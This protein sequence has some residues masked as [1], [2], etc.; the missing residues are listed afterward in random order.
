M[1]KRLAGAFLGFLLLFAVTGPIG[2]LNLGEE[3]ANIFSEVKGTVTVGEP[4][5]YG[6]HTIIPVVRWRLFAAGS[7][8][9]R[10]FD[11]QA[12]GVEIEPL[13]LILLTKD[14]FQVIRIAEGYLPPDELAE[15]DVLPLGDE[16]FER[17]LSEGSALMRSGMLEQ[18]REI[19]EILV[20]SR[21]DSAQAHAML[22]HVYGLLAEKAPELGEKIR[23]GMDAFREFARALEID[24]ENP[25]ALMARGYARMIVPPPLGGVEL[26]I[27]D[28]SLALE[29]DPNLVLAMTGLAEAYLSIGNIDRARE[30]FEQALS[31]EPENAQALRGLNKIKEGG[32]Q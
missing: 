18:A 30:L 24:P 9:G 17:L 15:E 21:P 20:R 26:A 14:T 7:T 8:P 29:H 2:A 31:I 16:D 12:G 1:V 13:A 11:W 32:H 10:G 5:V 25:H 22:G 23:Y 4:V 6:E 28:F 19:F 3:L 27:E